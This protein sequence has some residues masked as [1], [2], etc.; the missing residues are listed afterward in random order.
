MNS[1]KIWLI[2]AAVLILGGCI[3]FG[4][5]MSTLKWDFTALSTVK[6]RTSSYEIS[7]EYDSI[8]IDVDVADVVLVPSASTRVVCFEQEK[9]PHSAY[10][11]DGVLKIELDDSNTIKKFTGISFE[12]PCITL[13]IPSGMY[14]A[15]EIDAE[16]GNT[17]IPEDF[18]FNSI[19]ITQSTGDIICRA[20]ATERI[21]LK[22]TTGHIYAE[23]LS[24]GEFS[25]DIST[26]RTFLTDIK[27]V[28]LS[29]NGNTGDLRLCN[30]VAAGS[31]S[32]KRTTG[33]VIFEHCD[34]AEIFVSTSTGD[35]EGSLLSNKT[36]DVH[37]TT[38]QID[39]PTTEGG[40]CR[41]TTTTGDIQIEIKN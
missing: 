40:L 19:S 21:A 26:G 7:E 39:V 8:L 37:T 23:S 14:G 24:A 12:T 41:I 15:L 17:E 16:T 31:L 10:V 30:V 35:V 32:L 25:A 11:K 33:T 27:C 29:S 18:S 2:T 34:A 5:V 28:S 38:G 36:F 3:I 9:S 20:S 22:T 4:A 6:Y 1:T 13:Y